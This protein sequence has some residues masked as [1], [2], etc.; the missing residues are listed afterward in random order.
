MN[1][2]RTGGVRRLN[3]G[4]RAAAGRRPRRGVTHLRIAK[5]TLALPNTTPGAVHSK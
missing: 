5:S 1:G 4:G 2:G 3:E